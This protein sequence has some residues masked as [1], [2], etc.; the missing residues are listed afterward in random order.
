MRM[1]IDPS[2]L[3]AA[4]DWSHSIQARLAEKLSG[5]IALEADST[6]I[7]SGPHRVKVRTLLIEAG[8]DESEVESALNAP[9]SQKVSELDDPRTRDAIEHTLE[10]VFAV[11]RFLQ[12][13]DVSDKVIV[14]SLSTGAVNALVAKSSW[15][16][17]IHIFVDADLL[18]FCASMSKIL[19]QCLNDGAGRLQ[20]SDEMAAAMASP[21]LQHATKD[22]FR[23]ATFLGSVRASKP[24]LI[25]PHYLTAQYLLSQTMGAFVLGHEIAHVVHGHIGNEDSASEV[26]VADVPGAGVLMFSQEAEIEA[27][28]LGTVLASFTARAQQGHSIVDIVSPYLFM[29]ALRV[30]EAC[31][32]LVGNTAGGLDSTHPPASQRVMYIREVLSTRIPVGK[33]LAAVITLADEC[34]EVLEAMVLEDIHRIKN[35]GLVP[36]KR[37]MLRVFD[38]RPAI[39]G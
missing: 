18:V 24:F 11:M 39:L 33:E 9:A 6:D 16:P 10:R 12:M 31:K 23:A 28:V 36:R 15:D 1:K 35:T 21:L 2:D 20:T 32:S 5:Q 19:I 29:R 14:S 25:P 8:L 22:L 37:E 7:L 38:E 4:R 27:D 26:S 30:L 3:Q 34:F 17:F 13:D